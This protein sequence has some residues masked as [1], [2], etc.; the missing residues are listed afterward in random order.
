MMGK[1]SGRNLDL[2]PWTEEYLGV[3]DPDKGNETVCLSDLYP[4][5]AGPI[6]R[7]ELHERSAAPQPSL[8]HVIQSLEWENQESL[9]GQLKSC[10][11]SSSPLSAVQ[12]QVS[13]VT[14][15]YFCHLS[16]TASTHKAVLHGFSALFTKKGDISTLSLTLSW[17][18]KASELTPVYKLS[19]ACQSSAGKMQIPDHCPEC[20]ASS[21]PCLPLSHSVTLALLYSKRAT[22][23]PTP[24]PLYML[25]PL[26]GVS[27]TLTLSFSH[28]RLPFKYSFSESISVTPYYLK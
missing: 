20:P 15:T 10:H 11:V 27:P 14:K 1:T 23:L 5:L 13:I 21:G 3:S 18:P 16:S 28:F 8:S 17:M 9:T 7:P 4:P 24:G 22:L 26:L 6:D 12:C 2:L 25:F 19:S